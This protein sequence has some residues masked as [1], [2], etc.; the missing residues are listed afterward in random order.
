MSDLR[1]FVDERR[2]FEINLT[3]AMSP[4]VEVYDLFSVD[5]EPEDDGDPDDIQIE[6]PIVEPGI[7]QF[8][9]TGGTS[10]REYILTIKWRTAEG[11]N[12]ESRLTL[13]VR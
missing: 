8:Y 9:V 10:L 7:A 13:L 5:I 11:E 6:D 1:K 4:G 2:Q 12:L 3:A